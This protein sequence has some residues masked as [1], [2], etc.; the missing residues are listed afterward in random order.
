MMTCEGAAGGGEA[1]GSPDLSGGLEGVLLEVE[2]K[3]RVKICLGLP[4]KGGKV[5]QPEGIMSR[6]TSSD[7]IQWTGC[8]LGVSLRTPGQDLGAKDETWDSCSS[9]KLQDAETFSLSHPL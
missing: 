2:A 5:F 1:D 3:V 8:R 4:A 9:A 7:E 6:R